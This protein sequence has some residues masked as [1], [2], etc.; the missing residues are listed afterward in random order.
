V[1][2]NSANPPAER[3]I[4]QLIA[5][6]IRLYGSNF[7]R[8][9]PLG[10][11]LAATLVGLAATSD[12]A[13]GIAILVGGSA[14]MSLSYVASVAIAYPGRID[15][16]RLV[17]AFAL[18]TF[19]FIPML[20]LA[21]LFV[22]PGV[23]WFALF[24]LSVQVVLIERLTLGGAIRRA[25]GLARADFVHAMGAVAALV[26]VVFVTATAMFL[27]VRAGSGEAAVVA[28]F[29]TLVVTSPVLFLGSALL[30]DDQVARAEV[31]SSRKQRPK[32][33]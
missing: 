20:F 8:S 29:L 10:I 3:L 4:G 24:G 7:W 13:V 27:A 16:G 18:A 9:L 21:P 11:P 33:A 2:S 17:G 30:Y 23:A 22:L 19:V 15:R 12:L 25:L 31:K 28:A 32:E 5:D 1:E 14:L 26:V 6:A